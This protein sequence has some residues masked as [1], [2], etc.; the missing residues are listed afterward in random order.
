[1]LRNAVMMRIDLALPDAFPSWRRVHLHLGYQLRYYQR[2]FT[3]RDTWSPPPRSPTCP[4][5]E[6]A[7]GDQQL[8][9]TSRCPV[10]YEQLSNP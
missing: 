6:D 9:I 2:A 7:Y 4:S 10:F 5:R 3:P 1:V 8:R